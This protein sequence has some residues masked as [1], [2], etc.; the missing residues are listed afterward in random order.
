MKTLWNLLPFLQL[1]HPSVWTTAINERL[2]PL[3]D[4]WQD[5]QARLQRLF[6]TPDFQTSRANQAYQQMGDIESQY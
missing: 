1:L 6:I 2:K 5:K 4:N 3:L